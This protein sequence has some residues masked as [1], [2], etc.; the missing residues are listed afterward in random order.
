MNSTRG[1]AATGAYA[2][3]HRDWSDFDVAASGWHPA[4]D[5]LLAGGHSFMGY[6]YPD[7]GLLF[8]GMPSGIKVAL[9]DD[10]IWHR[11]FDNPLCQLERNLGVLFC[12]EVARDAMAVARPWESGREDAGILIFASEVFNQRW[13]ER[14]AAVL[15]FADVGM[16]FKY[17]CFAEPLRQSDL[18]AV[19]S[20]P[21][22]PSRFA[23]EILSP[24]KPGAR[25]SWQVLLD[26]WLNRQ[27]LV[28]AMARTTD[29]YPRR[30]VKID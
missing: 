7:A 21:Q 23:V 15:G 27:S 14:R 4:F 5:R 30:P 17:P 11:A 9:A 2:S 20:Y 6:H 22:I 26:T 25:E 19:L 29:C 13:R 18:L 8:R 12:S 10:Q 1:Q 3:D 28:P 16:V 24:S